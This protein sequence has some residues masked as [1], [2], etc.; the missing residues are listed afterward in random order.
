[1]LFEILSPLPGPGQGR[2]SSLR[3]VNPARAIGTLGRVN[4]DFFVSA[5]LIK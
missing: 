4:G 1:V 3:Q 2:S 5:R